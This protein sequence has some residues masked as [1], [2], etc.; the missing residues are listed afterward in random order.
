ML[1]LGADAIHKYNSHSLWNSWEMY[2]IA[3][4]WHAESELEVPSSGHDT[5]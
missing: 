1:T 2:I 3:V 4:L 5:A